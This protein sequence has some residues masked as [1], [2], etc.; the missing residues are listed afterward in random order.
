MINAPPLAS[1]AVEKIKRIMDPITAA[2]LHL[3]TGNPISLLQE[4]LPDPDVVAQA[5]HKLG[6]SP[7]EVAADGRRISYSSPRTTSRAASAASEAYA[8]TLAAQGEA[9]ARAR[10][11]SPEA[12]GAAHGAAARDSELWEE[13]RAGGRAEARWRKAEGAAMSRT[14]TYW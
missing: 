13:G 3:H 10:P 8:A 6:L 11:A 7:P 12:E 4:L 14:T 2:K 1:W 9:L 5:C